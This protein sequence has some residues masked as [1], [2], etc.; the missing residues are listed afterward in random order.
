MVPAAPFIDYDKLVYGKE[1]PNREEL[2][3]E[4]ESGNR[5]ERAAQ[6]SGQPVRR[7]SPVLDQVGILWLHL[8]AGLVPLAVSSKPQVHPSI[9]GEA[10]A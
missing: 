5:S 3:E 4:E 7:I 10:V 1:H 6:S 2:M 8:W 9:S